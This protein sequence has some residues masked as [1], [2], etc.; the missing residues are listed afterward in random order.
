MKRALA[1]YRVAEPGLAHRELGHL[2]A[3]GSASDPTF[4]W[5]VAA[6][7]HAAGDHPRASRLARTRLRSFAETA[8]TGRGRALWRIAYP[9]AF[10]PLIE[11]VAEDAEVPASFVRAVAREES[12]FNPSAVSVAHAYGL[13]QLIR[14]TAQRFARELGL[15]AT[16]QALKR[17]EINL[18]IGTRFISFL[19][20]HYE[21]NP[22]VVPSAYNAGEGAADR[23]LRARPDLSLDE[24][25]EEI[26]YDETRRYT[27]RVLQSY[28]I[29]CWLDRRELPPLT[30]TLPPPS[31]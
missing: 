30:P 10:E 18:P 25:I 1:L 9:R 27:R 22:A 13:I 8:P 15:P 31:R 26:P 21:T 24:W 6:V 14:P 7:L 20:S 11:E 5:L 19:W 16:P 23:W 28:G 17:P 2:G 4:L 29:Y 3:F 12:A